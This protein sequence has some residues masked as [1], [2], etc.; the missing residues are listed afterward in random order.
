MQQIRILLLDGKS[1]SFYIKSS[2]NVCLSLG[3]SNG[4]LVE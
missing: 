3:V 1:A 4:E 2:N